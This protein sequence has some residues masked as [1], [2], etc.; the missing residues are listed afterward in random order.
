MSEDKGDTQSLL[1]TRL[2]GQQLV[3]RNNEIF[4]WDDV[5]NVVVKIYHEADLLTPMLMLL[6]SLDG[7]S[8]LFEG[9]AVAL[10]GNW[11]KQNK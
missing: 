8:C 10:D 11:I 7:V 9:A 2:L 4:E 3:V 5:K 6:G 1:V